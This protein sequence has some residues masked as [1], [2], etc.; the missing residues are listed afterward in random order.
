MIYAT[1]DIH[2][3][4]LDSFLRLLERSGFGDDDLL[5][6]LGDVIDRNGDGGI[7]MLRWMM[8]RPNV[9]MILGNH[10]AMLLSCDFLFHE[11]TDSDIDRL[12]R[13]QL[14]LLTQWLRNGAK[15]TME[16]LRSLNEKDPAAC[17]DLLDYLR[18]LP[19]YA[20]V[21]AGERDFLMTHA[22]LGN[23]SPR[24]KLSEYL[25]EELLWNRPHPDDVYFPEVM[26]VFGHT[27]TG[28]LFGQRGRMFRT[29]TWIDIDTGAAGGRAPMLLRLD[30][31][32]P[33]YADE[34]D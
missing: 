18:D 22:G 17:R 27:P 11:I 12:N 2:G 33:F 20:A 28:Y 7:A 25:P 30:D 3:Y 24:K 10:E 16:A 5:Y 4:S 8:A 15:P 19:L 29:D 23:F 21:S 34:A 1:S 26:T 31:L 32:Q 6:V 14:R 13:E 9:E